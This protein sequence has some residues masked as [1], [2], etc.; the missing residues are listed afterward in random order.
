MPNPHRGEVALSAAGRD[1]VLRLSSNRFVELEATLGLGILELMELIQS[2]APP[3]ESGPD[4]KPVPAKETPEQ[5]RARA[6]KV[7]LSVVRAVLHAALLDRQPTTTLAEAGAII[8]EGGLVSIMQPLFF[9]A[10]IAFG[11]GSGADQSPP[12][13]TTAAAPASVGPGT[14]A[15]N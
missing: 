8:D 10:V 11:G 15:S 7:R 13:P 2:W 6:A 3:F 1:Y 4:G 12:V 9:A 5:L 14:G